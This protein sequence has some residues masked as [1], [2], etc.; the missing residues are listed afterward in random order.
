MINQ[1]TWTWQTVLSKFEKAN[2][3]WSANQNVI[4]FLLLNIMK[5]VNQVSVSV[6]GTR[7]AVSNRLKVCSNLCGSR[8][9]HVATI[10][11]TKRL[12]DIKREIR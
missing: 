8:E 2:H 1:R 10:E 3:L 11:I 6:A 5:S 9:G 12:R 7:P 4:A